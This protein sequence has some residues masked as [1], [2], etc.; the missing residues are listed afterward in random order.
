MQ[1]V[2]LPVEV[3]E[4]MEVNLWKNRSSKLIATGSEG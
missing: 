2:I 4:I 1:A 3:S